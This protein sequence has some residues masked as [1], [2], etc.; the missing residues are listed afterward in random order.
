MKRA[1]RHCWYCGADMGFESPAEDRETCGKR[2]CR[3]EA[4]LSWRADD[5]EAQERAARDNWDAYR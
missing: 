5:E 2:E 3:R 1:T 4:S